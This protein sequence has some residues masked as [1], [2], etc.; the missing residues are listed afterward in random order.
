MLCSALLCYAR[1]S[2]AAA[3]ASLLTPPIFW[4]GK[5][6]L[7]Y[8]SLTFDDCYNF[9]LLQSLEQ[10]LDANPSIKVIPIV[11]ECVR[12]KDILAIAPPPCLPPR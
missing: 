5:R 2:L 6:H 3:L 12:L 8:L 9:A 10:L 7:P 11:V 1:P 4:H